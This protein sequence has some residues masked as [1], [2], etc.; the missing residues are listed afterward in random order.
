MRIRHLILFSPLL[1]LFWA[2]QDRFTQVVFGDDFSADT[3]GN[4]EVRSDADGLYLFEEQKF[5][6]SDSVADPYLN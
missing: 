2:A 3:S 4:W 1:L 5:G 6:T